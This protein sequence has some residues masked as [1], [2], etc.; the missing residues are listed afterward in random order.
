MQISEAAR[1]TKYL[2][3]YIGFDVLTDPRYLVCVFLLAW[4]LVSCVVEEDV[5]D[6]PQVEQDVTTFTKEMISPLV[7]GENHSKIEQ[8]MV[9][10]LTSLRNQVLTCADPPAWNK[11]T[12]RN[13]DFFYRVYPLLEFI[14]M[15]LELALKEDDPELTRMLIGTPTFGETVLDLETAVGHKR[16]Q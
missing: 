5:S 9:T 12:K 15:N 10:Q 16:Q 4:L 8:S 7:D 2:G 1:I 11:T 14:E 6:C 13:V 3:D